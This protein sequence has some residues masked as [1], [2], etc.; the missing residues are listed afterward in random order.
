MMLFGVATS[1]DL[2]DCLGQE[3]LPTEDFVEQGLSEFYGSSCE[4][5]DNPEYEN[6]EDCIKAAKIGRLT[7]NNAQF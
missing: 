6:E 7:G 5:W 2:C 4:A 3:N 1:Q